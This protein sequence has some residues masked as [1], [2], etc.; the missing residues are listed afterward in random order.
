MANDSEIELA[1]LEKMAKILRKPWTVFL[2]DKPEEPIGYGQ[3]HRTVLN[4]EHRLS[5]EVARILEEANYILDVAQ[6]ISPDSR[7]NLPAIEHEKD[8][9]KLAAKLRTC[10]GVSLKDQLNLNDGYKALRYWKS[11]VQEAG[12]Y[13]SEKSLPIEEVRAFSIRKGDKA[14]VVVSTNDHPYARIFS[15]FHEM[16][17]IL[18][19]DTGVCD[20]QEEATKGSVEPFCNQFAASFLMPKKEFTELVAPYGIQ[21]GTAPNP[22][23]IGNLS[24][25]FS[26]SRLAVYTRLKNLGYISQIEYSRIYEG[27]GRQQPKNK[28]GGGN[29]YLSTINSSGRKFSEEVFG[30][31]SEGRLSY[32]DIGRVLGVATKNIGKL[33]ETLFAG[34]RNESTN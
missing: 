13:I 21:T 23:D 16:C 28:R 3:D 5:P 6:E 11:I 31:H 24:R 34:T 12:I 9:E 1:V 10:W 17:H 14:I 18:L 25:A 8:P 22:A 7:L 30:A 29:Y 19:K 33:R 32:N 20:L 15:I 27:R 2:L 26:V 4:N